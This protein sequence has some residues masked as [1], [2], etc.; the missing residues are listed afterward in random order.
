MSWDLSIL[1][2]KSEDTTFFVNMEAEGFNA[3]FWV[4]DL[5]SNSNQDRPYV[6]DV[7][8]YKNR[9]EAYLVKQALHTCVI[10]EF[11]FLT[12]IQCL[13]NELLFLI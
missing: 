3:Y 10:F 9:T 13:I 12:P 6:V 8:I 1:K 5:F 11:R 7:T 4:S 2:F